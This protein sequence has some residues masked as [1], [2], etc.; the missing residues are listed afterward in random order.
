MTKRELRIMIMEELVKA[1][2]EKESK[3]FDDLPD[4]SKIL[5]EGILDTIKQKIA[6][7]IPKLAQ[8]L[9]NLFMKA[10][11]KVV[12]YLS[13]LMPNDFVKN[14]QKASAIMVK[15]ITNNGGDILL[16]GVGKVLGP[17]AL[18]AI[19]SAIAATIFQQDVSLLMQS[20][21]NIAEVGGHLPL[22]IPIITACFVSAFT[23]IDKFKKVMKELL[24]RAQQKA[25]QTATVGETELNTVP[26]E[27]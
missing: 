14:Y 26:T 25:D 5:A 21:S 7:G 27:I 4:P 12:A 6:G 8:S 11:D 2:D 16:E 19:S 18:V 15:E 9:A 20:T 24:N 13:K 10:P 17:A 1:L 23:G 22:T 3:D